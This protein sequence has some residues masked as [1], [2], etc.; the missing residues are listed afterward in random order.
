MTAG[1]YNFTI[2]QGTDLVIPIE[3]RDGSGDLVD[4]T[5]CSAA[6]MIRRS[7]DDDPI[8]SLTSDD[9]IELGD[10][11]ITIGIDSTVTDGLTSGTAVYDLKIF[12]SLGNPERLLQGTI[13]FSA[14]VTR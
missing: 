9:G 6:M 5:G 7:H 13:T 3:C 10:G 1:T 11:T 4:L 2:E 14:A 8:V 12:D